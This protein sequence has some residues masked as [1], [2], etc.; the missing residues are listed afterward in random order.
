MPNPTTT[1]PLGDP[2]VF[3]STAVGSGAF[4]RW[5]LDHAGLPA[6][7]YTA[8]QYR[9]PH[10]YYP[11]SEQIDRRDH[12]HQIGNDRITAL[13]S[14]DG[15][16]QVYLCDRGGVLLN[17]FE[18]HTRNVALLSSGSARPG[19]PDPYN[20]RRIP[21]LRAAQQP[22]LADYLTALHEH[23]GLPGRS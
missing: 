10:A 13:A 23:E 18:A 22:E 4:G 6:Y 2:H 12:W 16:I 9:N 5:I 21:E 19:Q 3:A 11:N 7:Q 14:N 20:A 17:R 8:D 1:I 15:T